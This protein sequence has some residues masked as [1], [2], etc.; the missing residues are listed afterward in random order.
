MFGGE[1]L[2]RPKPGYYLQPALFSEVSN[3]MRIA[4]KE[5]FGPVAC[6]N[7]VRD[8]DEALAVANETKSASPPASARRV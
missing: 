2:D 7:R 8:Y 3:T 4:P 5:I 6:V 1:R